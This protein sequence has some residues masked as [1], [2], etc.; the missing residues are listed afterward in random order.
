MEWG[1]TIVGLSSSVS[2]SSVIEL[3]PES[4]SSNTVNSIT[5]GAESGSGAV[6]LYLCVCVCVC[7]S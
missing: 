4:S 3:L 5:R 6:L 7:V 2:I 1:R